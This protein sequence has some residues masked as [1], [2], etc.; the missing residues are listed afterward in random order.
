MKDQQTTPTDSRTPFQI[1]HDLSVL[2]ERSEKEVKRLEAE[3]AAH[4]QDRWDRDHRPLNPGPPVTFPDSLSFHHSTFP[5]E[6]R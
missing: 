3:L 1:I 2:L 4:K 6:R 5:D